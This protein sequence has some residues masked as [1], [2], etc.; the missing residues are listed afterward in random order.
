MVFKAYACI[1]VNSFF[2]FLNHFGMG[3]WCDPVKKGTLSLLEFFFPH[4]IVSFR[5][6][7]FTRV[8]GVTSK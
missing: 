4:F 5:F 8:L 3:S 2:F 7:F 6:S 1:P